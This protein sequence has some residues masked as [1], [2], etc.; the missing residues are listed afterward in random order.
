MKTQTLTLAAIVGALVLSG[1]AAAQAMATTTNPNWRGQ[2]NEF[3][4][5]RAPYTMDMDGG[6][7]AVVTAEIVIHEDYAE[8]DGRFYMFMWNVLN[9]PLDVKFTSLKRADN[10]Q[11]VPCYQT[12]GTPTTQVKCTVDRLSMP[13]EGTKL[14]MEG[15][16][17]SSRTGTFEVGALVVP[18]TATWVKVRMSNG[19]EAEV[20]AGTMI[21]AITATSGSNALGGLGNKIPAV[22][23]LGVAAAALVAVGLVALRR[24]K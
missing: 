2:D 15:E 7:R 9:T 4:S 3:A 17:G 10:G 1:G 8:K 24:R 6:N 13:P 16:V 12:D 18:F 19:L 20:Y 21:N 11:D 22:G 5:I 14:I 23:A